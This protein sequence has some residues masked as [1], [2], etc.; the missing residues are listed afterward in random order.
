MPHRTSSLPLL[1]ILALFLGF[2]VVRCQQQPT[3][4][5]S[6]EPVTEAAFVAATT[7]VHYIEA[8]AVAVGEGLMILHA[9]TCNHLAVD[10]RL[11]DPAC[12][13]AT[14][15]LRTNATT[16][17]PKLLLALQ[18][19]KA[20]LQ[21]AGKKPP[22][23]TAER[24]AAALTTLSQAAQELRVWATTEHIPLQPGKATP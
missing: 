7:T 6:G 8:G 17:A 11:T 1:M 15:L 13:R 16:I 22:G 21:L 14:G 19:A 9:E 5:L 23:T 3:V 4:T 2:A 24:L 12:V 10:T 18:G 20:Q